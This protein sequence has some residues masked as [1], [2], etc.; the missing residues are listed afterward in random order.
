MSW[1]IMLGCNILCRS[2]DNLLSFRGYV[3]EGLNV[4]LGY[5]EFSHIV[6]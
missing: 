3:I 2:N 4:T 5:L 6:H 1:Y